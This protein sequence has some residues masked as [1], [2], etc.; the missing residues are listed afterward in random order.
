M[1]SVWSLLSRVRGREYRD[2][3]AVYRRFSQIRLRVVLSARLAMADLSAG[4]R[5]ELRLMLQWMI[6]I[7]SMQRAH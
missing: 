3:T 4:G 1:L 5:V 2:W 6:V 7:H